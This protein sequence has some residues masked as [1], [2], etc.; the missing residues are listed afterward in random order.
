M[1]H[2]GGDAN[3]SRLRHASRLIAHAVPR[4][5]LRDVV[6]RISESVRG[7]FQPKSSSSLQQVIAQVAA[8]VRSQRK[9]RRRQRLGH[10]AKKMKDDFKT[11]FKTHDQ[12]PYL[13][14]LQA[15]D[16]DGLPVPALSACG[17]GTREIR[18]TKL[19]CYYLDPKK[20][21]GLG[22][23]LLQAACASLVPEPVWRNTDWARADVL[24][25]VDLGTVMVDGRPQGNQLDLLILTADH[26]VLIEQKIDSDEDVS[27]SQ[28]HRS[29]LSRYSEAFEKHAEYSRYNGKTSKVFLTPDG[30][31]ARVQDLRGEWTATSHAALV[32]QLASVLQSKELTPIARHNLA[33]LLIDLIMG[34][35][36]ANQL[37]EA[38][39]VRLRALLRNFN[40]RHYLGFLHWKRQTFPELDLIL[41]VL[42]GVHG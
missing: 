25:E 14:F 42:E 18:F 35:L 10:V 33:T 5:R 1:S 26:A 6:A 9:A 34:P 15:L 8:C 4:R 36:A 22:S 38:A 23:R 2:V 29:Q 19:L 28:E 41:D 20:P 37:L 13:R 40:A 32:S 24:A 17:Q 7:R 21:H 16:T 12:A 3:L 11:R 30:R 27:D 31:A 39:A